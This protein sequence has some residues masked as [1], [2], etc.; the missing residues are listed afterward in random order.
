MLFDA[1]AFAAEARRDGDATA[2]LQMMLQQ[3]NSEKAQLAAENAKLKAERDELKKSADANA[4]EATNERAKVSRTAQDLATAQANRA[5]LQQGFDTLKGRFDALVTQY[6]KTVDVL[7]ELEN[8]RNNLR[9]LARDYDVRV[10]Q[11]ER[12]NETLYAKNLE[13]I[14]LY[15]HKGVFAALKQQEPVTGI[16]KVEMENLMEEYRYQAEEMRLKRQ[17]APPPLAPADEPPA[18]DHGS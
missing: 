16:A 7:R 4:A 11:C 2:R 1:S 6:K 5:S 13:L 18:D 3:M 15:E 14:E 12:N 8:E 17:S 9:T 10:T